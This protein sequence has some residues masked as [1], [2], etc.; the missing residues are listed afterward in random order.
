MTSPARPPGPA[1]LSE[2]RDV[3]P[4]HRRILAFT[5]IGWIFDFYD[6]LLLSFLVASTPLTKDLTLSP[7]DVSVLLGTALAFTAAGG[8]AGGALADRF[9]RKPLLMATILVYCVGTVCSGLSIGMWTMLAS[10]AITGLGVGGEW[11]VAHALVGE[12]VPPHVRGR[13]GSYL[14]SGAAFARFLATI[15]GNFAAPVIGWRAAFILSAVPALMVVLIRR[16]MPESD[17][18]QANRRA[19]LARSDGERE[20][21][22]VLARMLGPAL[23]KTT[24]IATTMTMLNMAA[25]W[26][27]TIWLPTYFHQVRGLTLGESAWLLFA[28]QVGSVIGYIGFGYASDYF[29]RRPSF[30]AFSIIK[31]VGLTIVTLGWDAAHGYSA[32]MFG[33]MVLVGVGEGN[34]G[35]IGPLLNEVFPTDVRAAALGVIY[36]VSRGVQF[37]APL[38]ITFV[39]SRSSFG[40]GI[41][42][43]APFAL[44]A[45]ASVWALP[46]TKGVRIDEELASRPLSGGV[47]DRAASGV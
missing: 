27:K 33:F 9:G 44:L 41:A 16:Q 8:L 26:F 3:Q 46:E 10:R 30:S 4:V 5:F 40:T 15:V 1:L 31:A 32:T 19:R 38:V 47:G 43:A 7:Y 35:C 39:A 6:L 17:V 36:N 18:W 37:V 42:L 2:Y 11:A 12:T 21:P 45:G 20:R 13:Y 22:R 28:D 34:W 24:A 14:Q 25:Y 29:G 23:R